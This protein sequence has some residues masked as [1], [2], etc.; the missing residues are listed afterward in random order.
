MSPNTPLP[1]I[2]EWNQGFWEAALQGRLVVQ[3][4]ADCG[5]V[6]NLPRVA[7][8]VCRSF[9]FRWIDA[10]TRGTVYSWCRTRRKFHPA[11]DGGLHPFV[12]A[13]V[14][15]DRFPEAHFITRLEGRQN[16]EIGEPVEVWF[17]KVSEKIAL[18]LFR[19]PGLRE[20]G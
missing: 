6:R 18:P 15:L 16:P 8:P 4:C 19:R 12:L 9:K 20:V 3:A 11:F 14:A 10:G 7:C 2:S 5:A 17:E 1:E 13:V